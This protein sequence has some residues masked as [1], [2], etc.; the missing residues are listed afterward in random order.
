[1]N[2]LV[3][4]IQSQIFKNYIEYITEKHKTLPTNPPIYICFN[5]I[6]KSLLFKIK[7]RYKLE[8][9]KRENMKLMSSTKKLIDKNE[10]KCA[11]Y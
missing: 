6:N 1:M 4:I 5:G 3:V 11:D 7:N 9:Q 2:Y 10:R 8:I